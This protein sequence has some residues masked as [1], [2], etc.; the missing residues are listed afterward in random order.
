MQTASIAIGRE[1]RALTIEAGPDHF[2]KRGRYCARP[3][4]WTAYVYDGGR[5]I[6]RITGFST[7]RAAMAGAI[8]AANAIASRGA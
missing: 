2:N 7:K 6:R 3:V 1:A 5:C 4:C 8:N